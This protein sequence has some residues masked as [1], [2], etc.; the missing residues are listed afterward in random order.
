[1]RNSKTKICN[2]ALEEPCLKS[3]EEVLFKPIQSASTEHLT[4]AS[5]HNPVSVVINDNLTNEPT[6][7]EHCDPEAVIQLFNEE[8]ARWQTIISEWVWSM[9]PM[10]DA[11]SLPEQVQ[12]GWTNWVNQV[13]VFEF[14]SRKY[15][16]NQVALC[17]DAVQHE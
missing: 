4:L 6:F 10:T 8:L 13:P 14:N 15:D 11:N 1:M 9:Y 3:P 5:A 17:E 16:L 2:E 12:V 7:L